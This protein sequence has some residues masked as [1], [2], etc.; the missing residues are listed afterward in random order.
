MNGAKALESRDSKKSTGQAVI[1]LLDKGLA[2]PPQPFYV[3][4]GQ[5]D[6]LRRHGCRMVRDL[7]HGK[8][9]SSGDSPG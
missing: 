5:D 1:D 7:V 4:V 3:V 9:D 2:G 6:V 8:Q